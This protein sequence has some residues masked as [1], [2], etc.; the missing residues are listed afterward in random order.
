MKRS[1]LFAVIAILCVS[2][3]LADNVNILGIPNENRTIELSP[4]PPAGSPSGNGSSINQSFG[5]AT[6]WRLNA[7]NDARTNTISSWRMAFA[8]LFF[9]NSGLVSGSLAWTNASGVT[10]N[11]ISIL[12]EQML[13]ASN[14]GHLFA[15]NGMNELT[16][17]GNSIASILNVTAPNLCYSNGTNCQASGGGGSSNTTGSNLY[18]NFTDQ[19]NSGT[20]ETN[21]YKFSIGA[22]T[23]NNTND[24]ATI[25]ISGDYIGSTSSKRFQF[26]INNNN[27]IDSGAV[28]LATGGSWGMIIQVTRT[29]SNTAE[30]A[31]RLQT[32][33][34]TTFNYDKHIDMSGVDFTSAINTNVT[35]TAS[36]VGAASNDISARW[37]QVRL[38]GG[39]AGTGGGGGGGSTVN[40]ILN[41]SNVYVP[42]T[43]QNFSQAKLENISVIMGHGNNNTFSYFKGGLVLCGGHCNY[44]DTDP[45]S[46]A[47]N[48]IQQGNIVLRV[49][50][51]SNINLAP[52]GQGNIDIGGA[53]VVLGNWGGTTQIYNTVLTQ[54]FWS[55]GSSSTMYVDSSSDWNYANAPRFLGGF[56]T[57]LITSY[58]GSIPVFTIGGGA[59]SG[60]VDAGSHGNAVNGL[61]SITSGTS[62]GSFNDQVIMSVDF[63]FNICAPK[64]VLVTVTPATATGSRVFGSKTGVVR[65]DASSPQKFDLFSPIENGLPTDSVDYQWVYHVECG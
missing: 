6:Y 44:S 28:G 15:V 61:I 26:Y 4:Q 21:L 36:G 60:G 34:A 46:Q 33:T 17:T 59:C 52:G 7:A 48:P 58:D 19:N 35:G 54:G 63:G 11:S 8:N 62:C 24:T 27:T 1:V 55:F 49:N 25:D 31:S 20:A 3:V 23:L 16:I 45:V 56:N 2:F 41:A 65:V 42:N 47:T 43:I 50:A 37:I 40:A 32:T 38:N 30:V 64:N 29:G 14:A 12:N 5:D 18:F 51:S 39:V 22:G 53:N 10:A 13:H 57:S 9:N